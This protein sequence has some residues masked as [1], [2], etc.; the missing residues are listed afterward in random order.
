MAYI[1]D[2]SLGPVGG[3]FHSHMTLAQMQAQY[4]PGWVLANGATVSATSAFALLLGTTTLPNA[5]GQVLRGK[6]NGRAD[7]NQNPDGDVTLGTFQGDA[8]QGHFHNAR[9]RGLAG[10]GNGA[11]SIPSPGDN[12]TAAVVGGSTVLDTI[13][14]GT[15]GTPRTA[16]ES[17]MK[18]IT[19]NIFIRI[20]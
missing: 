5:L 1:L 12:N 3:Y 4:G 6:N 20:N 18:N 14:D 10:V 7:G 9:V 2:D 17:R 11:S 8:M 16:T 13:T 19:T 15:N